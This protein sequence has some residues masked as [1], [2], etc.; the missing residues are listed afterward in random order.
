VVDDGSAVARVDEIVI[1]R[2]EARADPGHGLPRHEVT[3]KRHP[4]RTALEQVVHVG[5][6]RRAGAAASA[7]AEVA[8]GQRPELCLGD[9]VAHGLEAA[10]LAEVVEQD[11]ADP[12]VAQPGSD[13]R[14]VSAKPCGRCS[15][16]RLPVGHVWRSA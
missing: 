11:P 10:H 12:G 16:Q 5:H 15:A 3:R 8:G 6:R 14:T 2:R 7:A 9:G 4:S 1:R 13:A